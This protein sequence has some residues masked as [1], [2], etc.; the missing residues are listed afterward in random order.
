MPKLTKTGTPGIYRRHTKACYGGRCDCSY[1]VVWRHRGKQETETFRTMAEARE[2]KGSR[3][4]GDSRP[5]ARVVLG[6]YFEEWIQSYSGRTSRGLS[7]RSREL[8]RRSARDHFLGRWRTW[9]LADV[10]P[11][12]VRQ[13][14]GELR[15]NGASTSALRQLRSTLSAMFSTAFEDGLIRSNPVRGVRIPAPTKVEVDDDQAKALTRDE[16]RRLL[17]ALPSDDWRLFF[18]F[19]VHTGLR[20][21]EAVGLRWEHLDLGTRPRVLVREQ[22]YEGKRSRLKSKSGKRDVPLSPG[23]AECLRTKRATSYREGGP[24]FTTIAGTELSRPNVASR[25][26]KPAAKAARLPWASFHTFRHTCASMLFEEGRNVKQVAEWLG[27]ADPAFTLRTYVH[28]LDEGVGNAD[29]F[30]RLRLSTAEPSRR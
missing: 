2:A 13:L 9:K 8:Y 26:L 10:E 25:V 5:T 23:M 1:V 12:D 18:E 20:I 11:T 28:L 24:V 21:S 15:R 30:D 6:D 16:L 3:N 29:F 14:Y 27:H 22:F 7:E 4:A 17:A 19:L